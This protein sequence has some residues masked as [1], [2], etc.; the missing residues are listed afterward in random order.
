ME[1]IEKTL[2]RNRNVLDGDRRLTMSEDTEQL[3]NLEQSLNTPN[4]DEEEIAMAA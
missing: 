1:N 4:E 2:K 3:L